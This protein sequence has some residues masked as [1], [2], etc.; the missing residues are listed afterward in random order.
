MKP[1]EQITDDIKANV[2]FAKNQDE[3]LTL[4]AHLFPDGMVCVGIE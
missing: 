3:Y 1:V 2:E 4:P